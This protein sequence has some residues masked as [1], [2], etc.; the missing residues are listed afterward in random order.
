ML[1]CK[2]K[3][4]TFPAL[5]GSLFVK[6]DT[7]DHFPLKSAAKIPVEKGG[8]EPLMQTGDL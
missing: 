7:P 6:R 8:V 4:R 1:L 5:H 2:R 3:L